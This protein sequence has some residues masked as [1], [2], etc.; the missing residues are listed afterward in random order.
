MIRQR[1]EEI[2]KPKEIKVVVNNNIVVEQQKQ[3]FYDPDY[4]SEKNS[5]DRE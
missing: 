1:S 5:S 3:P 4:E 2:I